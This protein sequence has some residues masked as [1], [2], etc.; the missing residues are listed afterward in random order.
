M[1]TVAHAPPWCRIEKSLKDHTNFVNCVRYSPDGSR[2]VSTSSDRSGIV[3]DGT[4]SAIIGRLD[5]AGGHAGSVFACAWSPDSTKLVTAGGDK[6]LK[7]WD[8]TGPGPV[9]PCA[10]TVAVGERLED[11]Q[12][13]V[14]WPRADTIVSVSLDGTLT[15]VSA[16][17]G[18]VTSRVAGHKD[19]AN[20]IAIDQA[21]GNIYTGDMGGRVCVWRARDEARTVFAA[22]IVKGG[23]GHGVMCD[24]GVLAPRPPRLPS[25]QA[26]SRRSASRA[27]LSPGAFSPPS[28]GTTSCASGTP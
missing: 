24:S 16:A 20:A 12:L 17:A 11:M 13:G 25:W 10:A 23:W 7:L 19:L 6:R 22:D 26:R 2:F 15:Y 4:T 18:A 28:P 3:Y 5:P 1:V 21:S 8:M 9:Y 27:L 14:V